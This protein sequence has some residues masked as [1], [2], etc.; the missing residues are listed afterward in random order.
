MITQADII[1]VAQKARE[2]INKLVDQVDAHEAYATLST[3]ASVEVYNNLRKLSRDID[4]LTF[5]MSEFR[6]A[7]IRDR[8][9][10][11]AS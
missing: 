9:M 7:M 3:A 2:K 10:R 11:K 1:S 8:E 6:Q 4:V 5:I